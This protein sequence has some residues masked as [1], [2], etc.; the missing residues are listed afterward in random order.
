MD[1]RLLQNPSTSAN[2]PSI[3]SRKAPVD[4]SGKSI[5]NAGARAR[6]ALAYCCAVALDRASAT[7]ASM[8]AQTFRSFS[9]VPHWANRSADTAPSDSISLISS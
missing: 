3:R 8:S 4:S 6:N 7:A 1:C 9:S 5:F 2:A